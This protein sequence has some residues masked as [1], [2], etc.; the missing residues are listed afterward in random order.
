MSSLNFHWSTLVGKNFV[1]E[2]GK[3]RCGLDSMMSAW[4]NRIINCFWATECCP[5]AAQCTLFK[6]D[7]SCSKSTFL[8]YMCQEQVHGFIMS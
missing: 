6:I 4:M 3:L 8:Y 7:Q 1:F 2:V 5:P